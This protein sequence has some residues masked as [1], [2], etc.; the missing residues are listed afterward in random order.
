MNRTYI[1]IDP[2]NSSNIFE[3]NGSSILYFNDKTNGTFYETYEIVKKNKSASKCYYIEK[4]H[5]WYQLIYKD[6]CIYQYAFNGT[7]FRRIEQVERLSDENIREL[8]KVGVHSG[9]PSTDVV[10]NPIYDKW[11]KDLL[12]VL[13]NGS[14][15]TDNIKR[16]IYNT[17][18]IP[19]PPY[20]GGRW[21]VGFLNGFTNK[22]PQYIDLI[23]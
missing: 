11:E 1:L 2:D 19:N 6:K 8:M 17:D 15:S 10:P 12:T 22:Y 5:M 16:I 7:L 21:L 18:N 20:L 13:E 23:L 14:I 4:T 9:T 3:I